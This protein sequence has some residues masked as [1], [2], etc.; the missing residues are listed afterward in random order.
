M[1]LVVNDNNYVVFTVYYVVYY[2]AFKNIDTMFC[3]FIGANVVI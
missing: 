2:T 3:E 1:M